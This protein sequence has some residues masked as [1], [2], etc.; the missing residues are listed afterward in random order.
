MAEVCA[1]V[2]GCWQA[3]QLLGQQSDDSQ[4]ESTQNELPAYSQLY[5][6]GSAR[7]I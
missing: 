7:R 2:S 4:L 5:L 6:A 3:H 1:L